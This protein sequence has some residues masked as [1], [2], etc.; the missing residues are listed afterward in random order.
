[1]RYS[2]FLWSSN[3]YEPAFPS[4]KQVLSSVYIL[5]LY[6]G[7]TSGLHEDRLN[8]SPHCRQQA[9]LHIAQAQVKLDLYHDSS[10]GFCSVE[11]IFHRQQVSPHIVLILAAPSPCSDDRGHSVDLG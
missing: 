6:H 2:Y 3:V 7:R 10:K 5:N 4:H 9:L 1:M 8:E 11:C